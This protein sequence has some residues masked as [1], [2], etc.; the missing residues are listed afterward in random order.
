[1]T[2]LATDNPASRELFGGD[3]PRHG[4]RCVDSLRMS[5]EEAL[6]EVRVASENG[7]AADRFAGVAYTGVPVKRWWGSLVV[8]L[9]TLRLPEGRKPVLWGHWGGRIGYSDTHEIVDGQLRIEGVLLTQGEGEHHQQARHIADDARAGFPFELSIGFD[10]DAE[11]VEAGSSVEVNGQT[12]HG[13]ITV[14]RRAHYRE[15]SWLEL[16]ADPFTNVGMLARS[17]MVPPELL[18]RLGVAS[19]R[20]HQNTPHGDGD[21]LMAEGDKAVKDATAEDIEKG[22][23]GAA[24]EIGKKAIEKAAEKAKAEAEETAGESVG[25]G[26]GAGDDDGSGG[27]EGSADGD[28]QAVGSMGAQPASIEEL[29]AIDGV[30]SDFVLEAFAQKLTLAQAKGMAERFASGAGGGLSPAQ[31]AALRDAAA[32]GEGTPVSGGDGKGGNA[33]DPSAGFAGLSLTDPV[34]DYEASEAL[35]TFC[36]AYFGNGNAR[37]GREAFLLYAEADMADRES[38]GRYDLSGPKR[39][40]ETDED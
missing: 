34:K 12:C 40:H 32:E 7:D 28:G 25:D 37:A 4:E 18:E 17:G 3:R 16:G 1:M 2:A 39:L 36:T 30:D 20:S 19:G 9:D 21:S 22:N 26:D 10:Y 23:P 5:P 38:G 33:G 27:S 35:R 29:R 13:P 11:E 8:D 15:T 31:L 6:G 24:E 14:A